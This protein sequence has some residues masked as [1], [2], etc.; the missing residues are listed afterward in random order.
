MTAAISIR[1]SSLKRLF[2]VCVNEEG[3][4]LEYEV[5]TPKGKFNVTNI[6]VQKQIK[7]NLKKKK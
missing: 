7:D 4:I 2:D 5:K 3:K 1:D 6:E